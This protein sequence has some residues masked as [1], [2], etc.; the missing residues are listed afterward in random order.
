MN[1]PISQILTKL[2][3]WGNLSPDEKAI[4]SQRALTK[5]FAKG[6]LVSSNTSSCLGIVLIINGEI[7]IGLTSDEGREITLYRAHEGDICISTASCVIRQLTFDADVTAEKDTTVLVIPSSICVRL[8]ESNIHVRAFV[9]EKQ[10]ERYSQTVWAIQ[11]M[12]FK[13]FDQ[14]LASYLVSAYDRT[15]NDEIKKTQEEIARDV[16]SA[17][18]VVARMLREFSTRGLV[19]IKRGS[20]K[21]SDIEA[22]RNIT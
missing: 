5:R 21:L 16:N 18:E 15:G 12:L 20:I 4:V 13:R 3:F 6:Q 7:R 14:R 1:E 22:L 2:P 11:T 19:K 9:F 17:R 10:T 8:M